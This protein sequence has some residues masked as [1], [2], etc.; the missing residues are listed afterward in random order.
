MYEYK[1]VRVEFGNS[2]IHRCRS[3]YTLHFTDMLFI[4]CT[5]VHNWMNNNLDECVF[6]SF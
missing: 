5:R 2:S 3:P 6:Y 4:V 1:I